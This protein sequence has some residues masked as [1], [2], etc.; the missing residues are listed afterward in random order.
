MLGDVLLLLAGGMT[1]YLVAIMRYRIKRIVERKGYMRIFRVEMLL[2]VCM[3]ALAVDVRFGL[4]R[5]L[6]WNFL[7]WTVRLAALAVL[8]PSFTLAALIMSHMRDVPSGEVENIIVPGL[9]LENGRPSRELINRLDAARDYA[10]VH[11]RTTLILSGG[12][13]GSG[14]ISE[15]QVMRDILLLKGVALLRI[16]I[17]DQSI[18]TIANLANVARMVDPRKP[19]LLVTSGYHMLRAS[20]LAR[21]SGFQTVRGLASRCDLIFLPANVTWEVICL[22]N[23]LLVGRLQPWDLCKFGMANDK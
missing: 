11:S 8:I 20:G 22:V 12:N 23:N 19:V 9:A 14:A 16:R 1:V 5:L 2:C 13:G 15:A 6:R 18:D 21:A 4:G 3:I 17:E 7:T 10:L